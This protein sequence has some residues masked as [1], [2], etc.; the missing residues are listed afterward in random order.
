[1]KIQLLL[2]GN[3][4]MAGHTLDSN[5]AMIA[6]SLAAYG[7]VIDKKVTVGDDFDQLVNEI[8]NLSSSADV[9]II[10]GGL[11]PTIDDLTAQALAEATADSLAENPI[12]T[13]HLRNWCEQRKLSLN[14]ANLKQAILPSRASIIANPIGSAVGFSVDYNNCLIACT[15]GVPGELKAILQDSLI[16]TV[17]ERLPNNQQHILRQIQT[18]G[19]GES[20]LQQM[21]NEHLSDWPEE[22]ELGFRAGFPLLEVKLSTQ[23]PPSDSRLDQW[24]GKLENLIKDEI[25][26]REQ[27]TLAQCLVN[28]LTSQGKTLSTAESCTGGLIASMITEVAGAS[29]AFHAG[30]VSYSNDMKVSLLGVSR[31]TI[32]E[33][34]AVSEAVVIEM[35]K[36]ALSISKS[37]YAVAVSGIAGPDG[38]TEDKPVG[39]VWIAWGSKDSIK[40]RKMQLNSSRSWFQQMVAAC[41]LDLIRRELQGITAEP[42]Y[43]T[44]Y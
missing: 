7:Y 19:I 17:R 27:A 22:I 11:G 21:F 13:E 39:T 1:M 36:G 29:A 16:N 43:F 37:D 25:I 9:L 38:G 14:Q 2:T 23:L 40:T 24:Q 35:L 32:N 41:C 20:T 33:Q 18:F 4:L 34:G 26:G 44:R 8:R 3:E 6:Q 12:A 28:L 30:V 10:N 42:R 15:P 31:D 5:S